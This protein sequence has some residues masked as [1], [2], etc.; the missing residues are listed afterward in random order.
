MHGCEA[1]DEFHW[2]HYLLPAALVAVRRHA[3][4]QAKDG[5]PSPKTVAC[6]LATRFVSQPAVGRTVARS[7]APS[8]ARDAALAYL[9]SR[10]WR[11]REAVGSGFVFCSRP[12]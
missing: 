11:A 5:E 12:G 8:R 1:V 6:D 3:H 4:Q 7:A 9:R 2:S 10:A